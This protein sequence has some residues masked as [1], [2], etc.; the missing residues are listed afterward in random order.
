[1]IDRLV[2]EGPLSY[3][4]SQ[5][6]PACTSYLEEKMTKMPFLTK[7]NRSKG[8]LEL[9]YTYV[10]GPLKVMARGNLSILLFLLMIAKGMVMF[11]YCTLSPRHLKSSK[12]FWLKRRNT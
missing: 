7:G 2:K 1:M 11:I 6:L 5:P 10:C 12:N 8:I 4:T 3:L 9:I